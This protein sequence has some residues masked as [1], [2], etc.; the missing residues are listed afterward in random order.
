MDLYV[1][2]L[3]LNCPQVNAKNSRDEK[4]ALVQGMVWYRQVTDH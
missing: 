4:T 2:H 1:E 3:V